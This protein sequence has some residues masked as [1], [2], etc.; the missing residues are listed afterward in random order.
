MPDELTHFLDRLPRRLGRHRAVLSADLAAARQVMS[1]AMFASLLG[2][3]RG[4]AEHRK[5]PETV[6]ACA[7]YLPVIFRML[8]ETGA[9]ACLSATEG[10]GDSVSDEAVALYFCSIQRVVE[11]YGGL[12][13]LQAY[14]QVVERVVRTAPR[15]LRPLL[16]NVDELLDRS[17]LRRLDQWA[18]WGVDTHASD[19]RGLMDYFSI[20]SAES[21]SRLDEPRLGAGFQTIKRSL[22]M[23]L[24]GFW[25]REFVLKSCPVVEGAQPS[26]PFIEGETVFL[27]E[28]YPDFAGRPL[29][30]IYHAAVTH[31]VTHIQHGDIFPI[32][33]RGL[34]EQACIGLFEDA[35]VEYLAARQFPA[36][37]RLWRKFT[38][39]PNPDAD[40]QGPRDRIL[41]TLLEMLRTNSPESSHPVLRELARSFCAALAYEAHRMGL[42]EAYGERLFLWMCAQSDD[43]LEQPFTA[44]PYRDDNRCLW[45]QVTDEQD[46]GRLPHD[47]PS[48]PSPEIAA[49]STS[50]PGRLGPKPAQQAHIVPSSD[51]GATPPRVDADMSGKPRFYDEWDYREAVLRPN[52]TTVREHPSVPGN[53]AGIGVALARNKPIAR[54][55][56]HMIEAIR[57]R[58]HQR[59]RRQFDGQEIDLDAAV[60]TSVALRS[61]HSPDPRTHIRYLKQQRDL[62]V[63]LLLDLSESTNDRLAGGRQSILELT[64]EAT[65]L[66]AWAVDR[67]GDPFA[68][69]GFASDGRHDVRYYRLKN[70]EQPYDDAAKSRLAGMSGGLS[71][72]MGAAM[73]HAGELLAATRK[74]RKLLLLLS[75]GEP[76]DIDER[77]PR[78]LRMDCK[79]AVEQ[80]T[81]AGVSSYCLTLDRAADRYV[82]R[83]FGVGNY[84]I[85]DNVKR[86]PERLPTLFARLT[87]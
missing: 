5:D 2:A 63:L 12:R 14:L 37:M 65:A 79:Q 44:V 68:V 39:R 60:S 72:R 7:A 64:F 69:H 82:E 83:I 15:A 51:L 80:L 40:D 18:R 78:Y 61:G 25:G 33:G 77:D 8:D 87:A 62:A 54:K 6:L 3:C 9:R 36:L 86:L 70:F 58:E 38:P 76:A 20:R 1:P 13:S 19:Y 49:E 56:E 28:S 66:L 45:R 4:F 24:R 35:R 52:W 32:A 31:A 55:I 42:S 27:P 71:T 21:T 29:P 30:C 11:R 50:Q 47:L 26:R 23:Y 17:T 10:M 59:L 84:T 67:I 34:L 46:S 22:G 85:V 57:P 81:R 48:T 43:E 41:L 74:S 16:L 53:P 73:R 75:D